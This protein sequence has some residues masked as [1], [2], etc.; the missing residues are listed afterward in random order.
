MLLR[1][2]RVALGQTDDFCWIADADMKEVIALA[3]R[4]E[5]SVLACDGLKILYEKSETE[6]EIAQSLSSLNSEEDERLRFIWLGESLRCEREYVKY[7]RALSDLVNF[8]NS[9]GLRT[10][11]LKGYGLSRYYP[12]PSHRLIG[13]IDIYL[14]DGGQRGSQLVKE[15]L[16]VKFV[17][18]DPNQDVFVFGNYIVENHLSVL[19]L[20]KHPSNDDLEFLLESLATDA[21][22]H[23]LEGVS[24][25]LPSVK[26]N[27]VH[28]LRHMA[29]DFA[30]VTTSLRHVL[31]WGLFVQ[32]NREEMDWPFLWAI[33]HKS[34]MHRFLNALNSICVDYLGFSIDVLPIEKRDDLLRDRVL[35]EILSSSYRESKRP[36]SMSIGY[37]ITKINMLWRNRWKYQI[38]YDESLLQ[39]FWYAMRNRIKVGF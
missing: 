24:F 8:F 22:I 18:S 26:F 38:V 5:V 20:S 16:D 31:D 3:R 11:V 37:I 25:Y 14:Y 23:Q 15:C 27:S 19:S 17:P 1:L 7:I 13:D 10:M 4:Q 21:T 6:K 36:L 12:I 2:L 30:T 33:A 32:S 29:S 39:S 35:T 28:L 34:N 9:Q